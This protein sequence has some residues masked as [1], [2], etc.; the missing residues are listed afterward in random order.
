MAVVWSFLVSLL[1]ATAADAIQIWQDPIDIPTT[2]P[3]RCR[4][5]LV[6]NITCSDFLVSPQKAAQGE[7]VVGDAAD[8]Y[9]GD[10]CSAS[11]TQFQTAVGA[12]CGDTF[13]QLFVNST[14]QQSAKGIADQLAWAHKLVCIKDS[15]GYCLADMY[16][17]NKDVCSDCY[18]QYGSTMQESDYGRAVIPEAAFKDLLST[19]SVD[20]T[21][22]PYT[23]TAPPTTTGGPTSTTTAPPS[24]STCP[25]SV[26]TSKEGDTCESISLAQSVATDRLVDVNYLDYNC[27]TLTAGM[28]LC[29]QDTCKLATIQTNQTCD[30]IAANGGF[31]VTQLTSWNPTLKSACDSRVTPNLDAFAGRHIC[32]E[33]PGQY[34]FPTTQLPSSQPTWTLNS[35]M[36][37][38]WTTGTVIIS[39]TD[40]IVT[41]TSNWDPDFTPP[42]ESVG[43]D[44]DE[45]TAMESW[46]GSCWISADDYNNEFD[47][48]SMAEGCQTLYWQ[49]CYYDPTLPSPSPSL[50]RA[51]SVCTPDRSSYDLG[52]DPDPVTTP[53][54][55]QD[56]MTT[57]CNKFYKVVANDNCQ[58]VASKQNVTLSDF[59]AWNPA[60]GSECRNLQ[61]D[62]YVCVGFDERLVYTTPTPTPAIK[63]K[64]F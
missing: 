28:Q 11:I 50:A 56:G 49:Y 58:T 64:W 3:N 8:V 23:Y 7:T 20:A 21:K 31:S 54:P 47:P 37:S 29:I 57:G 48:F 26:Y 24:T 44:T 12:A 42:P 17:G 9:C 14:L 15:S 59:Y 38:S 5:A 34:S 40:S 62:V 53:Q 16:A 60:V 63:L 55:I 25:G 1:A 45:E 27:T 61:L 13:Y 51:P 10:T 41:V 36:F 22:Y 4:A 52:T 33:A 18:L 39:P 32:I 19:C 6:Q 46:L 2:V 43:W 30:D 35:T